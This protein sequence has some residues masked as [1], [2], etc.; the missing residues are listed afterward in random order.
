MPLLINPSPLRA[1]SVFDPFKKVSFVNRNPPG[2][3][4]WFQMQLECIYGSE[5]PIM[6]TAVSGIESMIGRYIE[7]RILID[8]AHHW[9]FAL[10]VLSGI[11]NDT[12]RVYP[13]PSDYSI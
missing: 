6:K 4:Q 12:K 1:R 3:L 8:V 13:K 2:G 5:I 9:S 11:L 7:K 10:P